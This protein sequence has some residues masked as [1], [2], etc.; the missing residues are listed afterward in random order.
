MELIVYKSEGAF[1]Y[2]LEDFRADS[3]LLGYF[4]VDS[5][6][7]V[8]LHSDYLL[9]N[10]IEFPITKRINNDTVYSINGDSLFCYAFH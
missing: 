6:R 10:L 2:T 3:L 4:R 5:M 1:T 9:D 7:K 8:K